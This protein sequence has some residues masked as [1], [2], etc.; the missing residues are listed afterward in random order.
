M[1]ALSLASKAV[2]QNTAQVVAAVKSAQTTLNDEDSL[3]FSYLT[4]HEAKKEEMESQ[5]K[6]LEL[7]QDLNKERAKLAALRKQHY[8]MAQLVANKVS[9]TSDTLVENRQIDRTET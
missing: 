8:H 7:E 2:N 5:V 9:S 4:L 3:D 1:N 6:M